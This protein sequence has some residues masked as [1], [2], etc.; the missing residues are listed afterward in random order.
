MKVKHDKL[1]QFDYVDS[2]Y[3]EKAEDRYAPWIGLFMIRF[4]ELEHTLDTAIAN[5]FMDSAHE[6]GYLV[7]EGLTLNN[8]IELFR[9]LFHQFARLLVPKRLVRLKRIVKN[10]HDLRVFRNYLAHA[11]WS[12]LDKTGY[13]RTR[14]GEKDGEIILKK[15]RITPAKIEVWIRRI[16]KVNEDLDEYADTM[17]DDV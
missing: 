10:L 5:H 3:I 9:K 11:N 16:E 15:V 7:I 4:S 8:K 2:D 14:I 1:E 6:M 17:H 13:V 12:T